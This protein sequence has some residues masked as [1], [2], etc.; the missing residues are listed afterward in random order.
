MKI[1]C[2]NVNSIKSRAAQVLDWIS[3]EDPDILML[4][5]LKC[6][7]EAFPKLEFSHLPYNYAISGQKTYNGVAILSKYPL[8]DIKTNFEGNPI[9]DQARFVEVTFRS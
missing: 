7:E 2:W 9:P 5:E 1:A 3:K 6:E 4:Q 8:E